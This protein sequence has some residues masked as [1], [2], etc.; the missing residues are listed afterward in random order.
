MVERTSHQGDVRSSIP[1]SGTKIY[2]HR[3]FD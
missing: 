1:L 2:E 3:R